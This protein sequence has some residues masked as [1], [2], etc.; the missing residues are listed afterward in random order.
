MS[1]PTG[2][3]VI[4]G[5]S[6][7]L[8]AALARRWAAPGRRLALTG[9]N[10]ARLEAVA[11][12]CRTAGAEVV[13]KALD[14]ADTDA[15][16]SFLAEIEAAEPVGTVVANAG[17]SFGER[18]GGVMETAEETRRQIAVNAIGVVNTVA[19][20]LPALRARGQGRIAIIASLA[21][22][23][24]LASAPGYSASK[25]A[26]E[27][28]GEA[29]RARLAA[30]GVAVIVVSIGFFDSAM[31]RRFRGPKP[32]H[33]SL[34]RAAERV[35]RGIERGERRVVFPAPLALSLAVLPLLPRSIVDA[36]ARGFRFTVDPP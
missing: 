16:S 14:V 3:V 33:W 21:A 36:I 20:L 11:S 22:R 2:S 5:A 25:A 19:P 35:A 4:T 10:P 1:L 30:D 34:E 29:L 8:G 13:A 9:R 32:F 26:A 15:M 23:L 31:G 18:P 7:G 28:Y 24:G 27:R 17:T 6:S 12:D